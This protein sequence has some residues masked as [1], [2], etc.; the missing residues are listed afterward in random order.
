MKL[1]SWS[2]STLKA[3]ALGSALAAGIVG[4]A[5]SLRWLV[6][7]AIGLLAVAFGLRFARVPSNDPS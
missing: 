6:W 3:G 1:G 7:V 2:V 4:M 5:L